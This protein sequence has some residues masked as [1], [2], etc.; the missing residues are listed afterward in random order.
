MA[1]EVT[2]DAADASGK[3]LSPEIMAAELL[4]FL[5]KGGYLAAPAKK[6]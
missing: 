4:A 5:E 1:A 3:L 6:A 2:L